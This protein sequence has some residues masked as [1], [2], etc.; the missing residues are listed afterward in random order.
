MKRVKATLAGI[1]AI[2]IVATMGLN[3]SAYAASGPST[4]ILSGDLD[5]KGILQLVVNVLLYGLGAV[6]VI[7]VIIAGILYLTA[8]DNETQV[9]K[10]KA[11]LFEISLG[12]LAWAALFTI[13]KW[14]IP[15]FEGF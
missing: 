8:R 10:A 14:L 7:G 3:M 1:A 4:S 5:V 2:V 6:A 15:G 13:L 12:L 11:R 9:A